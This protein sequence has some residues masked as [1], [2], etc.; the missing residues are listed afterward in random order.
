MNPVNVNLERRVAA[1]EQIN[2]KLFEMLG[3]AE[4]MRRTIQHAVELQQAIDHMAA[5]GDGSL[6]KEYLLKVNSKIARR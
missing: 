2:E 6:I 3:I 5:T 4:E 1:L